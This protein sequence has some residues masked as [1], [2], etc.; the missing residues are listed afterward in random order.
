[1]TLN[2]IARLMGTM[3]NLFLSF[4]I[5][6]LICLRISRINIII[7]IA[8]SLPN[9]NIVSHPIIASTFRNLLNCSETGLVNFQNV[10]VLLMVRGCSADTP[11]PGLGEDQEIDLTENG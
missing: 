1:M 9:T 6:V 2:L 10:T 11:V 3:V 8:T 7:I 5:K 4:I